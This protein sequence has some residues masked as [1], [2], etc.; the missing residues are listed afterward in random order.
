MKKVLPLALAVLIIFSM[1]T[2]ISASAALVG[3]DGFYYE[4]VAG[5]YSKCADFGFDFQGNRMIQLFQV[6]K[7]LDVMGENYVL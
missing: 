6:M 3:E 1:F 4:Y 2:S 5:K 7:D